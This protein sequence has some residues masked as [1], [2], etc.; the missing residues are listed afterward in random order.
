V[1]DF[2]TMLV[3]EKVV[4]VFGFEQPW[5]ARAAGIVFPFAFRSR[6]AELLRHLEDNYQQLTTPESLAGKFLVFN[7]QTQPEG[8]NTR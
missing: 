8:R 4:L 3:G 2:E 6:F 5:K 7:L 1:E